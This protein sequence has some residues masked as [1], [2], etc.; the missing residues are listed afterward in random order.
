MSVTDTTSR[1]VSSIVGGRASVDGTRVESRN[2]ARVEEVVATALLGDANTF[3]DACR[4]AREAQRGWAATPAPVRGNAIKRIGRLV[5]DNKESLSRLLTREIGKP[6]AESLGEVQEVVDTCDFFVSEGRRL[7]GQTV[8]SELPDKQLFT[9]RNPVGVAAIITAGNFPVAVPS[10]YIVPALLCGNAVVWKPAEYAPALGEALAQ[11]FMHGGL[12]DGVLNLVQCEGPS[13]FAGL[14]RA[15]DERLV[16]KVG[17]TGSSTVGS[18]IGELCGRNLQSPCLE[19]GGKNPLVVMPDAELDLAVEGAL[20]SGFGTAGQRCT[21]LGTVIVHESVHDEFMRRFT[22]AVEGAAVGD[23]FEDVIYGPMIHERFLERFEGWLDLI[24]DHHSVSGSTALGRITADAPRAGFVGDADAGMFCH[25]TIVD[26]VTR[27]DDV[28]KTETFGPIVGVASFGDFDEAM[29]LANGHGYGL[30]S[31][32]YTTDP[33][34]AFRFRERV[35]A[36]MVSVNNSTSGAE[37]HLPFG[38]NGKSG[39]GSRQSGIW[40]LDQFTRWQSLNWDY[41]GKLQKAQMDVVELAGD[42]GYRL[43]WD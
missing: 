34:S 42:P 39:N 25:P 8:P 38:G 6:Y 30:S 33:R 2:P 3:V 22:A 21:S 41:A 11:L 9:F 14:E 7:Y 32:I 20:F 4:A 1:T 27:D 31:A 23:P 5:E 17:F 16:D 12:P 26:G 15:L 24:R 18:K 35:S 43:D 36:G 40:V 28:Y 37:A 29:D 19:L 13:A 10:W